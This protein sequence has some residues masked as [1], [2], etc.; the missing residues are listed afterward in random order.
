MFY[1]KGDL[2]DANDETESEDEL[3]P[4]N[5]VEKTRRKINNKYKKMAKKYK[6]VLWLK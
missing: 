6:P 5:F 4:L 2:D 1:R 3:E